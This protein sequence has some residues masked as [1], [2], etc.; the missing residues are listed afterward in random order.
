MK[1]LVI[2]PDPELRRLLEV[3]VR[4]AERRTGE[5]WQYLE[6]SNGIYGLKVAWREEPD[7]VVADEIASGAGAFAVAKDL[8]GAPEPF[9]GAVVLVLAR[10]EDIWLARWSGADAWVTKPVDPF[11]LADIVLRLVGP[12]RKE[13]A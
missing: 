2:S 6:S 5:P 7:L 10:P 9:R 3:A 13:S 12:S 1:A 8:R 4:T 11:E